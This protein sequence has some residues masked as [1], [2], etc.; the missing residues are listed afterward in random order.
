MT[1]NMQ[2]GIGVKMHNYLMQ[3]VQV[4]YHNCWAVYGLQF[5]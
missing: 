2:I 4:H 1:L 5:A 3:A